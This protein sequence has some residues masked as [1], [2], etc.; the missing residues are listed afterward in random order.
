[1]LNASP[2]DG[3]RRTR[4]TI[5]RF[6]GRFEPRAFDL[7][8]QP[9]T[10]F[11]GREREL[12]D[13]SALLGNDA[14]RLL[15]ITGPGGVGKTRLAMRLAEELEPDFAD[16]AAFV[17]LSAVVDH[18]LVIDAIARVVGVRDT[19]EGALIDRLRYSIGSRRMLLLLDNFEQ[20]VAA[21]P[22]VTQLLWTCPGLKVLVTSRVPLHVAGEQEYAVAP[23]AV[24]GS[25]PDPNDGIAESPAVALFVQR[26]RAVRP[27]F[28]L[29]DANRADVAAICARLDGL[30]LAIELAAAR[31]KVLS[32]TALLTRLSYPL[33]VLKGGPRDQPSRLQTMRNAIAWSHD[34]LAEEERILF[35][36]MA[37]FSG[38]FCLE[39]AEAVASQPVEPPEPGQG[40]G[41]GLAVLDGLASLADKSLIWGADGPRGEPRFGM[42]ETVREFALE[43]TEESGEGPELRRRHAVWCLDLAASAEPA[44]LGPFDGGKL[45]HLETEVSNLRAA[46]GW[47]QEEGDTESAFRLVASLGA[48]WYLRGR[49]G[50]G[51]ERLADLIAIGKDVPAQVRAKGLFFA[52]WLGIYNADDARASGWLTEGLALYQRMAD[53]EGVIATTIALGGAAEYRNDDHEAWDRYAEALARARDLGHQRL[54]VWSLVNL[55]DAA[56]RRGDIERCAAL[57]EEALER[58]DALQDQVLRGSAL[59]LAAQASLARNDLDR[60]ERLCQ[61]CLSLSQAYGYQSGLA[62]ALVGLAGVA[63]ARGRAARA[64][65]L[66]GAASAVLES[67]G[68]PMSFN[69]EQQRR[70]HAAAREALS[71]P[72]FAAAWDAGRTTP[73]ADLLA[74]VDAELRGRPPLLSGAERNCCPC[75]R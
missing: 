38:G 71:E 17:P 61:E 74:E 56:F 44:T 4:G 70:T 57:G 28:V 58:A 33:E 40:D 31:S 59:G 27:E 2:A 42:L 63:A 18:D 55:T 37:V 14:V 36:R 52:G 60:A 73:I 64:A 54:I 75:A 67:V 21:A 51:R 26:A 11:V 65:R 72:E 1:M 46:I 47:L 69:H 30:P 7:P 49:F 66:L 35:R 16:G 15:T 19:G 41:S 24:P 6:T 62:F 34:L 32:P 68:I 10:S 29:Q 3:N 13:L 12:D 50:E 20:V 48:F 8:P 9:L 22:D 45:D 5:S 39:A 43:R 23:L 25:R 53:E